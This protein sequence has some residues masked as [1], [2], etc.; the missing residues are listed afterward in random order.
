MDGKFCALASWPDGRLQRYIY[1]PVVLM[2]FFFGCEKHYEVIFPCWKLGNVGSFYMQLEHCWEPWQGL[3]LGK[4]QR[5]GS[6]EGLLWGPYLA[7]FSRLRSSSIRFS[8]GNLMNQGFVVFYIWWV[9][10]LP[11]SDLKQYNLVAGSKKDLTSCCRSCVTMETL[12]IHTVWIDV[13][14]LL[15]LIFR[16][17][18]E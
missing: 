15:Y 9:C 6:F 2:V 14:C 8:S 17:T 10:S 3:W 16:E 13:Q 7:L 18:N 11:F 1:V 12:A 5:V 4:R